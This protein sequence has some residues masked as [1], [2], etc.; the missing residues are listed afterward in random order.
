MR[1]QF[2]KL[3]Y[4]FYQRFNSKEDALKKANQLRA[5]G[6]LAHVVYVD[7]DNFDLYR[8]RGKEKYNARDVEKQILKQGEIQKKS[9]AI[10][11]CDV[12]VS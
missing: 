4:D 10:L 5:K 9:E 6:V 3:Y 11:E 1:K 2:G 7:D 12:H 8:Y